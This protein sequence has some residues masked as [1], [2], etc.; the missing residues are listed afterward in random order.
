MKQE[1]QIK[2]QFNVEHTP[3]S[4]HHLH[5]IAQNY[6][7]GKGIIINDGVIQI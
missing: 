1:I 3:G 2:V 4:E 6:F 7:K 5:S